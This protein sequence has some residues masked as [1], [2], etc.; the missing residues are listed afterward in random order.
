MVHQRAEHHIRTPRSRPGILGLKHQLA[1]GVH[2]AV[3]PRGLIVLQH[4]AALLA[5]GLA[6]HK[7]GDPLRRIIVFHGGG[8]AHIPV[9]ALRGRG[10]LGRR[11]GADRIRGGGVQEL[12]DGREED[13]GNHHEDEH[14]T[15]SSTMLTP[16]SPRR[17][18]NTVRRPT[19]QPARSPRRIRRTTPLTPAS[20]SLFI[21]IA[22]PFPSHA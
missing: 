16:R 11:P 4:H 7:H 13:A 6:R 3:R 8:I 19:P 14:A 17:A 20:H 2:R 10:D 15:I 12:D 1:I 18:G 21:V 22:P 9:D 5:G